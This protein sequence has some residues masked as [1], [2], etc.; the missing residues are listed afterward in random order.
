MVDAIRSLPLILFAGFVIFPA[1]VT[2]IFVAAGLT[3]R[4]RAALMQAT[5]TSN[6]GM[7]QDGYR[8][9]EGRAEAVEGPALEAPLTRAPCVW[10]HAKV[11][12]FPSES[13]VGKRS[14]WLTVND[15]TSS[16]PFLI[17]DSTGACLVEPFRAE[18]TPTDKSVWY[19]ATEI[20]ADRN[21]SRVGP[22]ESATGLIEVAGGPNS[23]FR[24]SE[25]R[26]YA[27]DPLLVLGQFYSGRH[28][29]AFDAEEDEDDVEEPDL[30]GLS[31]EDRA[32][33]AADLA[34]GQREDDIRTRAEAI[35]KAWIGHGTGKQPFI[36]STTLQAI[37]VAQSSMGAQAVLSLA[38]VP[39]A[40]VVFLLWARFS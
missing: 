35:T 33:L 4:R 8:E 11:E 19:G 28:T 38:A 10:Y 21:P 15:V 9:F 2:A 23:K 14:T 34:K 32:E 37:D 18:V 13:P 12:R 26:I 20:P 24:Y 36:L 30:S 31:D 22:G 6:I 7:A 40:I 39:A 16:A 17:R 27:G 3:A 1:A 5:P 29:T 25:E